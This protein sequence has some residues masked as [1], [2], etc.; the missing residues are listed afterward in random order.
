MFLWLVWLAQISEE[1]ETSSLLDLFFEFDPLVLVATLLSTHSLAAVP[2]LALVTV[3]LSVLLGRVFCGWACPFGTVHHAVTWLSGKFRLE[4]AKTAAD[5]W[6]GWQRAK[7]L[8][9]TAL[10]VMAA[11][12]AHW[13]GVFDP[14]SLLYRSVATALAPAARYAI[15]DASTTVFLAD[16]G[17][18]PAR[19]SL[20]TE[21]VYEFSRDSVFAGQSHV[22]FG[23][24]L[25]YAVF[26]AIVLLNLVRKRF[27]CRYVCP[28]GALLGVVAKRPAMRLTNEHE[29][30]TDCGRCTQACPAAAEPEK[31]DGWRSTE[32]YECWNCVASCNSDALSFTFAAPFTKATE[33]KLDMSKRALISAGMGG[34]GSL[35]WFRVDP[36]AQARTF[37][38]ALIRPPGALPEREFLQRCIQCGVC[39]KVCPTNFLHPAGLEAGLE[40]IWSPVAVSR[41]GFCEY[42]CSLCGQ[43]CPTEA[44]QPL[45][46]EEKK[47]VKIGLAVFDLSRCLPW[48]FGRECS[49]CEEHCPTPQ[50]AIYVID[51][52]VT[53]QDGT[54]RMLKQPYVNPDL[55]TGGGICENVCVFIDIAAVRITSA[56]E[57]RHEENVPFLKGVSGLKLP[58]PDSGTDDPYGGGSSADP[59]G[60]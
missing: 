55:C 24:G 42:E 60:G 49:V 18:G 39:M 9:L 10:L 14:L 56:N 36:Q 45:P 3:V 50:K 35:L 5:G 2:L 29:L 31:P 20:V 21:P 23:S 30:C 58:A 11:F 25:I 1:N 57:S 40:G 26:F 46:L 16:P 38:P 22:F 33:A 19:V 8:L 28:L 15:E 17:I 6:S 4:D 37:H 12:G 27:W 32:C 44:I 59:Y 41:V 47:K 13:I 48:A 53:L 52:E 54:T 51:E 7:Y 43:A 34:I